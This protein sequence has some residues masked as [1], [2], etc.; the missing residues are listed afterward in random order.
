MNVNQMF[1][2]KFLK[3][4]D[5]GT[6]EFEVTIHS[7]QVEDVG[8]E[9]APEQKPVVY[10]QEGQKGMPLNKTN[11]ETIAYLYGPETDGWIGKKVTLFP[12]MVEFK[13]QSVPAIRVRGPRSQAPATNGPFSQAQRAQA[14]MNRPTT[15]AAVNVAGGDHH[16]LASEAASE[17]INW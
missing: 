1:P 11:A 17:D 7:V 3:A 6:S 14:P 4:T 9:Q 5:L 13:G 12:M 15:G 10:F 16:P 2:S 8:T